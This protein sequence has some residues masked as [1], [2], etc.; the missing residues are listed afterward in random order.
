MA[1]LGEHLARMAAYRAALDQFSGGIRSTGLADPGRLHDVTG[2][3][4]NPGDLRMLKYVPDGVGRGA[5]L[6]VALHGCTQTAATYDLGSGWSH[7]ADQMGFALLM[8]EQQPSNNPN[9]CFT[10]FLTGDTRR[11][12]GE[13]SSIRQMV[14][15][16]L[17]THDLDRSRVFVVGLSAG[18]AM[19]SA[20]LA[21]YPDV[22]SAGAVIAGL[23]FGAAS[24]LA[25]AMEAMGK[26]RPRTARQL[27]DLVR[28]A[29]RHPGPWPRVS[30]WHG[31]TD[32]IVNP[33]NAELTVQQWLDV[34][35][36][37]ETPTIVVERAGSAR[38]SWQDGSG[39]RVVEA[40]IVPGMS[41]GVPVGGEGS[42]GQ[43][44]PYHF[45]VGISSTIEIA[46]FFGLATLKGRERETASPDHL[47]SRSLTVVDSDAR[48][49]PS[50]SR[51]H[52]ESALRRLARRIGLT[53]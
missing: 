2:F 29:A 35:D 53:S 46:E 27:G 38:R 48:L 37:G 24:G 26:S 41:H 32:T 8:P 31:N 10:W 36:L 7:L 25:E 13:A 34:H 14:E 40:V 33:L 50:S 44:G 17:V 23:P 49:T 4:T 22:F 6:V 3:G 11:S 47:Q 30:V 28:S 5:P 52:R 43:A 9:R 51:H 45:D 12:G 20:L 1:G 21:G 19:T 15:T 16:M 42:L 18:G 39:R